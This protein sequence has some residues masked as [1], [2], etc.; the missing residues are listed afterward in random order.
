MV[1]RVEALQAMVKEDEK[2][3]VWATLNESLM[4]D[5]LCIVCVGHIDSARQSRMEVQG[6]ILSLL[7]R[8]LATALVLL[9]SAFLY[10]TQAVFYADLHMRD[11]RDALRIFLVM[12]RD[13]AYSLGQITS[14][15]S[16]TLPCSIILPLVYVIS[17]SAT[18]L[19][20]C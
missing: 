7:P 15:H 14:A 10:T 5:M 11:V 3:K 17:S 18:S 9:S 13:P 19:W 6:F 4:D 16:R 8:T 2:G 12:Q 20:A 1:E